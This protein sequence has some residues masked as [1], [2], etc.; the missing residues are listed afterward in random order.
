[1]DGAAEWVGQAEHD[2]RAARKN[3]RIKEYA[4]AAFLAQQAAEKA[5][6]AVLIRRFAELPRVHDITYLGKRV[7][8]PG[9]LLEGGDALTQ[10]YIATRYPD[11]PG[12][13]PS[14]SFTAKDCRRLIKTAKEI[15]LWTGKKR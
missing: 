5:L 4:V 1:M 6:K 9:R 15:L 8:L 13:P 7:G 11:L 12:G 10:A 14:E 3:A 2:L